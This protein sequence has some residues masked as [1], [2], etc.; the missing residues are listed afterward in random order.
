MIIFEENCVE[1]LK[2]D[3][4][5][6]LSNILLMILIALVSYIAKVF[7]EKMETI[8][9]EIRSIMISDVANKKDIE[10]LKSVSSDHE[11]RISILES[12]S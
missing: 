5:S 6:Q 2:N 11:A 4:M 12:K 8:I 10:S 1:K 7:Y 9:S 3:E